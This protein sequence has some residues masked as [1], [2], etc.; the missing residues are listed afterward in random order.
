MF[1][2]LRTL[3]RHRVVGLLKEGQPF[4]GAHDLESEI[5]Q[6]VSRNF[7]CSWWRGMAYGV[8]VHVAAISL[9][10]ADLKIL[11]DARENSKGTL[12]WVILVTDS[13]HAA[14]A[15]H[16]WMEAYLS[17]VYRLTLQAL[18]EAGYQ[19]ASAGKEKNGLM[20]FLTGV[21]DV[22]AALSSL[23][24]RRHAFPEFRDRVL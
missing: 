14:V 8:L 13:A 1:W 18:S 5:R 19:V 23:G 7:K 15:V 10:H 3:N 20:K 17:P 6:A 24:T 11:V 9:S 4:A 12:Q 22:D 16:T 21:A 2:E